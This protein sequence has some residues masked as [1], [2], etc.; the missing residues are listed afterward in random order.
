DPLTLLTLFTFLIGALVIPDFGPAV[1][2]GAIALVTGIAFLSG[3][4]FG[5]RRVPTFW[6]G[7]AA[8][9]TATLLLITLG[10][11]P[12]PGYQMGYWDRYVTLPA[13]FWL[14]L[15]LSWLLVK[16]GRPFAIASCG[17]L[18]AIQL[19]GFQELSSQRRM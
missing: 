11:A 17:L 19:Q 9:A 6:L 2:V 10:R 1:F 3:E 13:L 18:L 15:G 12:M 5:Q 7:V 16:P 8:F 14:A 4:A